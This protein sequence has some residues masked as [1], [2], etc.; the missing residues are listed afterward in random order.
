MEKSLLLRAYTGASIRCLPNQGTTFVSR[1]VLRAGFC[2]RARPLGHRLWRNVARRYEGEC[3]TVLRS[4]SS[5]CGAC[6]G[7]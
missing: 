6:G 3:L 7:S 5:A 1:I 2:Q 4:H